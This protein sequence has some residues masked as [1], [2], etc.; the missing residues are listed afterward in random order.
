[1]LPMRNNNPC[2]TGLLILAI[3]FALLVAVAGVVKCSGG[4]RKPKPFSVEEWD[5]IEARE[6]G[7]Q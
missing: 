4:D 5:R 1:M 7:G 3:G 6:G 2:S